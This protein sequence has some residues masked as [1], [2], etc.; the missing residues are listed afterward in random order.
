[1]ASM[2]P[3]P[4]LSGRSQLL[5]PALIAVLVV[6][7]ISAFADIVVTAMATQ[8]VSAQYR[9]QV[10]GLLFASTPQIA[11]ELALIAALGTLG[12]QRGAVRGAAIAAVLLGAMV[13]ALVPFFTLDF[14]QSRR[15]VP[16]NNL[17]GFTLAGLKAEGFAGWFSL[18]MLWAGIRGVQASP[19]PDETEKRVQ[20]QGLVVGQE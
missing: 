11:V 19:R 1:M 17:K 2:S 12:G 18:M 7:I 9:F 4:L 14:L 20:G 16:Q 5:F 6:A 13:I 3:T 15:L 8:A 10:I